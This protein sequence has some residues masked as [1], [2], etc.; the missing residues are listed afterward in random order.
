MINSDQIEEWIQEVEERPASASLI[1]RFVANRLRDLTGRNEA[2]LAENIELRSGRKVQE[3]EDQIANLTYQLEMLKRQIGSDINFSA[4]IEAN[5]ISLIV[6]QVTGRVL[7]IEL[8]MDALVNGKQ[9]AYV[10]VEDTS[11]WMA[12]RPLV[13]STLEELLFVFDS[14]RT[15]TLP[16]SDLVDSGLEDTSWKNAYLVEPRGGEELVVVLPIGKMS[17]YDFCIQ[18]SRR[19]YAKKI[20]K[21]SF[22]S[23][24][25]KGFIGTGV[26]QKPDRAGGLSFSA[27]D[28]LLVLASYEGYLVSLEVNSLPFT[29]EETLRLSATDH[30]VSS[31]VIQKKPSF[32]IVTRNGKVVVRETGWLEK[33]ASSKGRGQPIF[34]QSRREAGVRVAGAAAVGDGDWGVALWSDGR[35]TAHSLTDVLA[36]GTL[37][38]DSQGAEVLEFVPVGLAVSG[39]S[40]AGE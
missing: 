37:L 33:P 40:G 11:A 17:L 1:V 14:G 7:R 29:A 24:V 38:D 39:K 27:K 25:A 30:I 32:M 26:K 36:T 16:V 6:F 23:Q 15:V 34:S 5:T 12:P 28:D 10:P 18:T 21:T 13:T 35:I 9:I 19:G 4:P 3:Y 31:F 2:L 22:E 8:E 20:M